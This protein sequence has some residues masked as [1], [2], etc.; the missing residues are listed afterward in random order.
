MHL[1]DVALGGKML[2]GLQML[3]LL[4]QH[5]LLLL[6]LLLQMDVLLLLNHRVPV[7]GSLVEE[8]QLEVKQP[9]QIARTFFPRGR[10]PLLLLL[11]KL[12]LLLNKLLLLLR[13]LDHSGFLR[14]SSAN[15]RRGFL[16]RHFR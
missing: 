13:R 9:H 1:L 4:G 12:L 7:V 10:E 14:S 2:R 8:I 16:R 3:L 15:E 5:D 6:L 11:N